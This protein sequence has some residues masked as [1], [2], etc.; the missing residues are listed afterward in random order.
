MLP[1]RTIGS[2][3]TCKYFLIMFAVSC[4][5]QVSL[6]IGSSEATSMYYKKVQG[7][8]YEPDWVPVSSTVIPLV[9]RV[10]SVGAGARKKSSFGSDGHD[11]TDGVLGADESYKRAYVKHISKFTKIGTA[12][13]EVQPGTLITGKTASSSAKD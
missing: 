11:G 7:E 6:L 5:L 2:V 12:G 8:K 9:E 4:F 13:A 3:S 1:N 10:V